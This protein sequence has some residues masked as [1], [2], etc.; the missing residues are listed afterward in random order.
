MLG[1]LVVPGLCLLR[2]YYRS[3]AHALP[4]RD[5]YALAQ[6]LVLSLAWLPV[7][8]VLG[9]SSVVDWTVDDSLDQHQLDF[10]SIVVGNLVLALVA[11]AVIGR[12]VAA[13]GEE[14]GLARSLAW[15]GIFEPP[16]A[17][18]AAWRFASTAAW[19]AVEIRLKNGDQF[20]VLFDAGS[21]V[22]LSPAPRQLFFDTEYRWEGDDVAVQEHEGIYIDASEVVSVRFEHI[23]G[24][25]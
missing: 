11:G 24:A 4:S 8:W 20:N 23:E 13:I 5:L 7:L 3:R 21:V 2:G 6:A 19:A 17:W 18:D 15:T 12:I 16:T 1:V 22:G 14:T 9:G 25:A 10:L